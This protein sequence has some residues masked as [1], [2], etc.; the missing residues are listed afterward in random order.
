MKLNNMQQI[1]KEKGIS[2]SS[3]GFSF[4][5]SQ[6]NK[7]KPKQVNKMNIIHLIRSNNIP[8]LNSLMNDLSQENFSENDYFEFSRDELKIIKSYQIL[9]QY[10]LYSINQL[11][12]KNQILN[13]LSD[14][15]ASYNEAAEHTIHKQQKKIKIQSEEISDL[16]RN[17]DNM[18]FLIQKLGLEDKVRELGIKPSS[19]LNMN[20]NEKLNNIMVNQNTLNLNEQKF[21]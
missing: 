9:T 3:E 12:K 7:I 15:Q 17:C 13:E 18:F 10:M 11:T 14:K 21:H 6:T 19:Y 4:F 8:E 1:P 20:E 5:L 2:I 16:S